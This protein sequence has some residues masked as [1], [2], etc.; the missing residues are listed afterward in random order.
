MSEHGD[1]VPG[2]RMIRMEAQPEAPAAALADVDAWQARKAYPNVLGGGGPVFGVAEE[3]E[4]GGWQI[5]SLFSSPYPQGS[6]DTMA[7]MFRERARAAEDAGDTETQREWL[8]N[9][10]RLDWEPLNELTVFGR[11]FRTVRG[12]QFIR[13][14]PTGPEPPRP[15]DPDPAKVGH[16]HEYRGRTKGFVIDP[17]TPTGMSEGILRMELLSLVHAKGTAPAAVRKDSLR[18]LETHPGGVLLPAEFTAAEFSDGHWAPT[19]MTNASPQGSRDTLTTYLRVMAP[20]MEQLDEET[21]AEYG[22]LADRI[23]A[24]RCDE[25]VIDGCRTRIVRVERLV[26]VGPDGPEGPRPSDP[27]PELPTAVQEKQLREEGVFDEYRVLNEEETE[28][29]RVADEQAKEFLRLFEEQ[30][31]RRE[32]AEEG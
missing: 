23:D 27:D 8:R 14:G 20:V 16:G 7:M 15:S 19:Q 12:D 13:M 18:A 4:T 31:K 6:R 1:Q 29:R 5:I 22:R 26:R 11:R 25:I 21:R 3:L 24:E 17:F 2:Y 28:Q 9:A 30:R 10:E 32:A